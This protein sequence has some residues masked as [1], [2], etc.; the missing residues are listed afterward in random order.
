MSY[1]NCLYAMNVV[2]IL[3]K[4]AAVL[5]LIAFLL[6]LLDNFSYSLL[7]SRIFIAVNTFEIQHFFFDLAIEPLLISVL[8]D[9]SFQG[10][11]I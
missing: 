3:S 5:S 8:H 4:T 2:N 9:Y 1:R 10:I 7:R 6:E 11:L